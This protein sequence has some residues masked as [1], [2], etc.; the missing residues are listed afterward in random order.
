MLNTIRDLVAHENFR[1]VLRS[2][3]SKQPTASVYSGG[4]NKKPKKHTHNEG[5]IDTIYRDAER[6]WKNERKNN[7]RSRDRVYKEKER[8]YG[9]SSWRR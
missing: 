9:R 2:P 7:I 4:P 8:P 5:G 1:I 6:D 3:H